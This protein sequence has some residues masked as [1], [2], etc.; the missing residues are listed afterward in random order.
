MTGK[1]TH[2]GQMQKW[3][4]GRGFRA[5]NSAAWCLAVLT[6]WR[7]RWGGRE[8][9]KEAA[10]VQSRGCGRD[11]ERAQGVGRGGSVWLEGPQRRGP[12]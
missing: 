11:N 8:T 5:P 9:S 3:G 6:V 1:N 7:E 12:L 4:G 2:S 10:G